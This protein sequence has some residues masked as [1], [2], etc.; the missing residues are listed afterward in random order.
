MHRN[1]AKTALKMTTISSVAGLHQRNRH[2]GSYDFT[3]LVRAE[4]ALKR[5]VMKNP[6]GQDTIP[7]ADADAVKLLNKAL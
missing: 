2:R 7:F 3:A 4:P 5:F 6:R 1:A